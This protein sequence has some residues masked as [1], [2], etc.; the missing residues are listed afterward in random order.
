MTPDPENDP[1]Y[2][3][4]CPDAQGRPCQR[5]HQSGVIVMPNK[6]AKQLHKL[7]KARHVPMPRRA[8]KMKSDIKW[9]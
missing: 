9:Y 2:P 7:S 8:R 6:M 3:F 5:P 1:T 4:D